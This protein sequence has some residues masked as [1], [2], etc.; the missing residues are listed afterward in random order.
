MVNAMQAEQA[1]PGETRYRR[2]SYF[3]FASL[4]PNTSATA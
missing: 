1:N 4:V 2:W 3:D